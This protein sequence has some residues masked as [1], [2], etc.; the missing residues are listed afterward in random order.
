MITNRSEV[1]EF[2]KELL[3]KEKVDFTKNIA[4]VNAMY[5]EAVALGVI[6]MKNPLDGLEIDVKIARV[7][8]NVPEAP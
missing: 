2:E 8:N 4:I 5:N 1:E 7:V 6:P 3:R